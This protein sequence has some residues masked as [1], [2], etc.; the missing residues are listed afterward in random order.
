MLTTPAASKL[1]DG[2]SGPS[3]WARVENRYG[4]DVDEQTRDVLD[5][6]ERVL[7]A[8]E[9]DPRRLT[10]QLDWVTKL[11]LLEGYRSRDGLGWDDARLHLVDLQYSDVR[12]DKGLYHRLAQR[13]RVER[14]LTDLL[15]ISRYD[16]G[17]ATLE[18]ES[19]NLGA[20]VSRVAAGM[21]SLAERHGCELTVDRPD[22]GI[23]AEVDAR[24]VE[25]ILRNR[26]GNAIEH[27]AGRNTG[28]AD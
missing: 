12:P 8:L 17:A 23:F 13:G 14:L 22:E 1:V 16:A 3:T 21:Y 26:V 7:V 5:R 15:E 10:G 18:A 19:T 9:S 6:W 20:L 28:V 4:S 24:R 25:R 27:G 2:M 11:E